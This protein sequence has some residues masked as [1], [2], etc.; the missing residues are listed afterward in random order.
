MANILFTHSFWLVLISKDHL[1]QLD[2]TKRVTTYFSPEYQFYSWTYEIPSEETPFHSQYI[3]VFYPEHGLSKNQMYNL[4]EGTH[5]Y[6]LIL[7]DSC[8]SGPSDGS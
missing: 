3:I 5:T 2:F 8:R 6:G 4:T 1:H 7:R